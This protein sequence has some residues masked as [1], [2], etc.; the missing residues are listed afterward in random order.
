MTLLRI[1]GVTPF[2]VRESSRSPRRA[3]LGGLP[4][5]LLGG[6]TGMRFFQAKR[7]KNIL[8]MFD[9]ATLTR[10]GRLAVRANRAK[11]RH[12]GRLGMDR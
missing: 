11:A 9:G 5:F 6:A 12:P 3:V 1:R 7:R 2:L 4:Y 10:N 8:E